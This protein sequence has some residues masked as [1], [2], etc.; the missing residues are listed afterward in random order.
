MFGIRDKVLCVEVRCWFGFSDSC[1][2]EKPCRMA[3]G[4]SLVVMIVV[5]KLRLMEII[6]NC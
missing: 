3:G 4:I 2:D 5:L 1:C 6:I